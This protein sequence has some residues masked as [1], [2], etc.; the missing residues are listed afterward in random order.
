VLSRGT[1]LGWKENVDEEA[2]L[3]YLAGDG[4]R[5]SDIVSGESE[6]EKGIKLIEFLENDPQARTRDI[7]LET[8]FHC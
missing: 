8:Y 3:R 6:E 4:E 1:L 7:P 2:Q 5:S